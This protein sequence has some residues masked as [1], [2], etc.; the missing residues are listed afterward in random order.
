MIFGTFDMIHEGHEDFFKQARRLGENVHVI[1][2]IARDTAVKRI[3]GGLPQYPEKERLALV[4]RHPLVDSAV[5]GD[6]EGYIPHI[7]ENNPDIIALGYDQVGEYVEALEQDL[8]DAGLQT[9][10]VRLKAFK[11]ETYKT[12]RL[13]GILF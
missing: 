4:T 10:I 12:S 2:S 6:E 7:V 5:L 8:R 3:K 11:P 1:V 13:R 9:R